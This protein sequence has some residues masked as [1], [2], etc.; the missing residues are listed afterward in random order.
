MA[1]RRV[2]WGAWSALPAALAILAGLIVGRRDVAAQ[3][4]QYLGPSQCLN[5]HDHDREKDWYM[6][7]EQA[8][9]SRL[10][11]AL[12]KQAG[13]LNSDKQLEDPNA[14]KYA[15]A[16]GLKDVYDAKGACVTC[17]GTVF[18][19]ELNAGVSCEKCHGPASAYLTPH[20]T[21]GSYDRAVAAGMTDVIGKPQEWAK[22]CYGCHI[23]K[24]QRLVKAGHRS[25]DDFDLSKKFGPVSKHFR[26]KSYNESQIASVWTALRS[27]DAVTTPA[28]PPAPTPTP[29][30]PPPTPNPK[31]APVP[32]VTPPA[33]AEPAKTTPA[34]KTNPPQPAPQPVPP[35]SPV[36]EPPPPAPAPTPAPAS[37]PMLSPSSALAAAQ[38]QVIAALTQL[39]QQGSR[40]PVRVAS[41]DRAVPYRGPDAALLEIQQEAI[42]LALKVLGQPPKAPGEKK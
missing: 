25:G 18:G 14:A 27:R 22:Q 21:K 6:K 17:H 11:P 2:A 10:F 26:S 30:P 3:Q 24:D 36:V 16:I 13:H 32:P 15:A 31:S 42:A 1:R 39:L 38:G 19:G 5:C 7:G 8:E 41:P 4:P 33:K 37:P 28:P 9:V 29:T 12:G 34:T 40:A 20:Q 23:V 35:P